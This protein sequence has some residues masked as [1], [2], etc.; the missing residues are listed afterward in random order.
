MNAENEI[1]EIAERYFQQKMDELNR[2]IEDV[3]RA[4]EELTNALITQQMQLAQ[5][6]AMVE[7]YNHRPEI[8]LN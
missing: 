8:N 3:T 7:T 1:P 6:S 5:Y 4:F 2:S